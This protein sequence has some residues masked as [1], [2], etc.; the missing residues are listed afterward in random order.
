[1]E[2]KLKPKTVENIKFNKSEADKIY[3]KYSYNKELTKKLDEF[4]NDFDLETIYEIILWKLNRFPMIEESLIN[5]INKLR[6]YK[7]NRDK[8]NAKKIL[9]ELLK[10]KGIGLP[11]AST[12]LRF[13]NPNQFQ[14]IDTRAYRFL[15]GKYL[16][17][18]NTVGKIDAL[19]FDY[20]EA[21]HKLAK[22]QKIKFNIM[23]RIL[24]QADIEYNYKIGLNGKVKKVSE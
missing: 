3:K 7:K 14:I 24:Y 19:Y 22:Q 15:T 12:I 23:D 16:N 9:N 17:E 10:I 4:K 2:R 1:M 18:K 20:L 13:V 8:D 21:L 11:I 5:S 6:N